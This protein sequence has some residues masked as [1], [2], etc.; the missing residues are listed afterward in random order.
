M[1]EKIKNFAIVWG[2]A[3]QKSDRTA[4]NGFYKS[5][6]AVMVFIELEFPDIDKYEAYKYLQDNY[7]DVLDS[8]GDML[9]GVSFEGD[10]R[11]YISLSNKGLDPIKKEPDVEPIDDKDKPACKKFRRKIMKE[12]YN[13]INIAMDNHNITKK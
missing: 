13:T 5:I 6:K 10:C 3:K 2:K 12:I 9:K 8:P 4:L 11:A 1:D 7:I